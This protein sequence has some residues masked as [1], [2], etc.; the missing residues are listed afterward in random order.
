MTSQDTIVL[1]TD[2]ALVALDLTSAIEELFPAVRVMTITPPIAAPEQIALP[3]LMALIA[4]QHEARSLDLERFRQD[5][6][7][8]VVLGEEEVPGDPGVAYLQLPFT[9]EMLTSVLRAV[10]RPDLV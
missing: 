4:D 9:T 10:T 8:I 6:A 1:L 3:G 7:A 5:G 2:N